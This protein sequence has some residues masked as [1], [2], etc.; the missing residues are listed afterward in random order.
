MAAPVQP[1]DA[2]SGLTPS[3]VVVKPDTAVSSLSVG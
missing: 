3:N 1:S 2:V